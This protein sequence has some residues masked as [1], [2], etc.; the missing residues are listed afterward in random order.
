M[1]LATGASAAYR[2]VRYREVRY[3]RVWLPRGLITGGPLPVVPAGAEYSEDDG[4]ELVKE[5]EEQRDRDRAR[6]GPRAA[7]GRSS[8]RRPAGR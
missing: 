8:P 6:A 1:S 4:S 2:G 3:R 5:D 7:R